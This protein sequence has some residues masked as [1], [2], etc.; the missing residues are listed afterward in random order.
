MKCSFDIFW[1]MKYSFFSL[2]ASE[3]CMP[4]FP[5]HVPRM[6]VKEGILPTNS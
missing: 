5:K 3:H 6:D 1:M 2:E 4:T